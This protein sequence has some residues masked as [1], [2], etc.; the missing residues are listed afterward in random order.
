MITPGSIKDNF[1]ETDGPEGRRGRS[2]LIKIVSIV[3]AL[4]IT[5]TMLIGFLVWRKRHEELVGVAPEAKTKTAH[6]VL[7]A[8][9]QIFM[10][11]AVRKGSEALIGGTVQNISGENLSNLT[12][13]IELAHR[14]DAGTEVR[15]LNVEPGDLAPDQKGRYSLTLTG[16]YRSWKLLRIKSGASSNEIGFKTAPG[17]PRPVERAPETTRTIVVGRPSS[18]KTGEEF[19]NTPDNP[20]KIP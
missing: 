4:A 18:P 6:T 13:E 9:V 3:L 5:A 1:T 7:P 20:S 8:K 10:D 17:A 15:V 2:S 14:K 19:I 12:V 16:N 11:E